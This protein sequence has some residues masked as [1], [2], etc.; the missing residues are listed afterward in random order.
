MAITL[1]QA[2]II[3]VVL[4]GIYYIVWPLLVTLLFPTVEINIEPG[5]RPNGS[6]CWRARP[7]APIMIR[8]RKVAVVRRGQRIRWIIP[9]GAPTFRFNYKRRLF[10]F[11]F[12]GGRG[13]EVDSDVT[14]V[15]RV[16]WW[17]PFGES[18]YCVEICV[19][20]TPVGTDEFVAG[21]LS[22]TEAHVRWL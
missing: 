15:R 9:A 2:V 22:H 7:Q 19:G 17:A 11:P 5:V 12:S 20:A 16:H 14:F 10:G 1:D 4:L 8:G 6:A 13:V 21:P 3:A 18:P